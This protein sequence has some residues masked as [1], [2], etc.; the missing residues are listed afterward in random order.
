MIKWPATEV[1]LLL[2][3][4]KG[5]EARLVFMAHALMENRHGMLV[6]LQTTQAT[7]RRS[8]ILCR[9]CWTKP[10]RG[11]VILERW[12]EIRPT[13]PGIA[14]QACD[15]AGCD[16]ARRLEQQGAVQRH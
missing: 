7:V 6:D 8:G 12:A 3:K 2:R 14:W 4:G 1:F 13:T 16:V 9:N 5:K 11:A 10:G 15:G